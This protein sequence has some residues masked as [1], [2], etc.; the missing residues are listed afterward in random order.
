MIEHVESVL[1]WVS[2]HPT[3]TLAIL[4]LCCLGESILVLGVLIPTTFVLLVAGALV[5]HEAIDFWPAL[6]A[7][8][9]GAVCGDGINFWVGRRWGERALDS[10]YA[11]RY[12]VAVAR[13]RALFTRHGAKALVLARFIGLVRPFIAAIAGAYRMTTW[14]FLAVEVFAGAIWAAPLIALGIVF[15]A[16]LGLASEVATRLAVLLMALLVVLA[17]LVWLVAGSVSGMQS[18]A[19]TWLTGLLDWSHR[20]RRLGRLGGWLADP[21]QPE[22]P[23]LV[24]LALV[25]F[26]LGWVWM[27]LWWGWTGATPSVFDTLAWQGAIDLR[28]PLT[29]AL[30]LGVAQLA[31]VEVY[32]PV[33]VTLLITLL[34]QGR[35]RAA[36]HYL[37]AVAFGTALSLALYWLIDV[38]DPVNYYRGEVAVRFG[39]RDLVLA[40]VIY[41]FVAVLVA[42]QRS[43]VWRIFCYALALGLV[44]LM[45]AADV[46]LGTVWLSTGLFAVLFGG[47]WVALLGLGYRRHGAASIAAR[48]IVPLALG[49]LIAS[50]A[51]QSSAELRGPFDPRPE[52][53][54]SL[55]A[56]RWWNGA[57][58]ELPAY[59]IDSAGREKQP[60]SVQWRGELPR[61]EK[62]LRAAGWE[63]PPPLSWENTLRWLAVSA[64]LAEL[65]VLPQV[66]AG[67]H[68][69]LVLRMLRGDDEQWV[70]RLWPSGWTAG[71]SPLWVGTLTRQTGR[72]PLRLVRYPRTE[73]DYDSPLAAFAN[74]PAGFEAKQVS[75]PRR[76]PEV[77]GW[78]GGLWLLRPR[79]GG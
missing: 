35:G 37:A 50:A 67:T 4:F 21:A 76:E 51:L 13:S 42:T 59:R 61:I 16:S 75:H 68:Q 20:H 6:A 12:Q 33:A 29:T 14:R 39:G 48:E 70:I 62:A 64:P 19:E 43:Q 45:L 60:L 54:R 57:H 44:T 56:A 18:R 31:D 72:R 22:T 65:P 24:L 66:H 27:S 69:A 8:I 17:L 1:G 30:A 38:P 11:Q 32:A 34:L 26:A 47:T 73:R 71:G 74:S 15:G 25:L 77:A 49:V 55:P 40:T 28:T 2:A 41:A 58:A 5:A 10:H 3:W 78:S 53:A 7:A 52:E 9:A 36:A 79:A 23:A 46:Y 63:S